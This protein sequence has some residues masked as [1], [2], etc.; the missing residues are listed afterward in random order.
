M[1]S[2]D[3]TKRWIN[4]TKLTD[5]SYAS[6]VQGIEQFTSNEWVVGLNPTGGTMDKQPSIKIWMMGREIPH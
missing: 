4:F 2:I 1:N 5:N 3:T 6:I